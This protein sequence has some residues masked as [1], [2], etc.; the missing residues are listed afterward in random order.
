MMLRRGF[1]AFEAGLRVALGMM[2]AVVAQALV[3]PVLGLQIMLWHHLA[4]SAAFDAMAS[5]C[6]RASRRFCSREMC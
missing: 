4:T 6:Q 5:L 2:I 1:F 3:Y